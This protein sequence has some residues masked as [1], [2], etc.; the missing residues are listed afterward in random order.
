VVNQAL[1]RRMF[2]GEDPVGK[3]LYIQ[4]GRPN[5]T[6]EIVGVVG[7]VHQKGLDQDPSPGVFLPTLQNP[8]SPVNLVL[9][10]SGDPQQL[11]NAVQAAVHSIDRDIPIADVKTMD[12]YVSASISAPRFNTMLLGGFAALALVLAAIGIFGVISYSVVQRTQEIGVRRALGADTASV[13]RL[14]LS[15]GMGLAGIGIAVGLAGAFAITRLLSSLLFGV[16]PTDA[17]TFTGVAMILCAVAFF[18]SYVPAR[19]ATRVDPMIALRY[20]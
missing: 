8:T 13:L 18:A 9:R 3:R 12:Q 7:D 14:V 15:E 4:W 6:Y 11:A 20:E 1:A 19:R 17:G 10:T 2:Q 16:T 5:D